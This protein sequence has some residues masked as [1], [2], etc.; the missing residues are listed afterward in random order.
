MSV[1]EDLVSSRQR[2]SPYN[3][4][5]PYRAETSSAPTVVENVFLF[6]HGQD[7]DPFALERWDVLK[8]RDF[9][10]GF[11]VERD[12]WSQKVVMGGKE[13]DQ[14]QGAV[15]GFEAA[16]WADMEFEGPVKALD[17]LFENSVK[18]RFFVEV[19]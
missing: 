19:L 5:R 6:S 2:T 7:F 13:D 15:V 4:Q 14:R 12:V 11:V 17:K 8:F 9:D 1:G 18:F 10:W 3:T 16:G